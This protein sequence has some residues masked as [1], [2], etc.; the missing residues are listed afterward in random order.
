MNIKKQFKPS[1]EM[2][3]AAANVFACMAMVDTIKPMVTGYQKGILTRHQWPIDKESR[4][5][6]GKTSIVLDPKNSWL[7]N[8][9]DFKAYLYECNEQRKAAGLHVDNIQHCPLL[10]AED[11][12][13][14]AQRL[15]AD[16]MESVTGITAHQIFCSKNALENYKKYID[17]NLR[18]LA[19]F[20]KTT[21]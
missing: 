4:R 5:I 9:A 19:P 2:I 16:T 8:E 21:K 7:L 12:L 18:L 15:L 14:Q 1:K 13:R 10:V 6:A 11:L 20:V 3:K 17:L